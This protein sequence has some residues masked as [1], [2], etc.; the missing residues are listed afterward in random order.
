M[1]LQVRRV[2]EFE[3]L[4]V[5]EVWECNRTAMG[6]TVKGEEDGAG[7]REGG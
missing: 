6:A 7:M 4:I 5:R 2:Y 3:R 1:P